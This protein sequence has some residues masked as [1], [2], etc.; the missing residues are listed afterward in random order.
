MPNYDFHQLSPLD[1]ERLARDLLQQEWSVRLESFKSGR[2]KGIDLRYASGPEKLVVQVK[3][4]LR[5]GIAGLIRDLKKEDVKVRKLKPSRYA[6]VTSVP[7]SQEDKNKI[8]AA[9][10]SAPLEV[11]DIYGQED[12]N[13]FLGRYPDIEKAHPKLWLTSQAILER[14]LNNAEVTRSEFE[15]QKIHQQIR[16]YAQTEA[17]REAEKRLA[18]ESVVMIA[19]PPGIGKTT[20]ANML[21]YEH[22]SQGWQ[23][24]V[25]DRDINEGAKLFKKDVNQIFYFDDFVGATL[26]GEGI[27][28]NDKALLSFI[29]MVRVNPSSRLILTT[30]EHLYEQAKTRSERLRH[31]NLDADRIVL[32]LHDYTIRQRAQ[33]LYNHIYFSDLPKEHVSALLDHGFYRNIIHHDK[34]NP[35]VIEWMATRQ[36]IINVPAEEYCN[37]VSQ[38][39]QDPIEIWRHAYEEELSKHAQTLLLILWSSEGRI[40]IQILERAFM[41][42]HANRV[43]KY[44][45]RSSPHNFNRALKELSGSFITPQGK[46]AVGVIDPSV[47]DLLSAV[48]SEAP[49]NASDI[50]LSTYSF[51]QIARL[52]NFARQDSS[53]R[54]LQAIKDSA[55]E[56]APLIH[57][58]MCAPRRVDYP[59]G[60]STWAESS[61]PERLSII[62]SLAQQTCTPEYERLVEPMVEAVLS[63]PLDE[64]SDINGLVDVIVKIKPRDSEQHFP[65]REKLRA[66][67]FEIVKNGCCSDELHQATRLLEETPA[68]AEIQSLKSGFEA[69]RA[70][71]FYDERTNCQTSDDFDV[72]ISDL[73]SI[74][75]I[76]DINTACMIRDVEDERQKF[77]E[78][79]EQ[80]ADA[81]YDQY[82]E[83]W[84]EERHENESIAD[85]FESLKSDN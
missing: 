4:Y 21:I 24:I 7:L 79:Q 81:T 73:N 23:A 26:I 84:R 74:G 78:Q 43:K 12:L 70:D 61:Y 31:A 64:G 41:K 76:L 48:L 60:T 67:V 1:L 46:V 42:F 9:V 32:R 28:A 50:L 6:V 27:T 11:S 57:Q 8:I 29:A 54:V 40:A 63:E 20:L 2:D 65:L 85:M 15:V 17:L 35:R 30:R 53:G 62:I 33:I 49:D 19:G 58:L 22:L 34:F 25:I 56:A 13:N 72:L 66:R 52:L 80:Y 82:K 77:E 55:S 5:T 44:G 39:L 38:L 37:F 51:S 71:Y 14:V 68:K 45:Y 16:R 69:Y 47:L 83:Q 59:N 36:R 75:K 3:H 18:D 10:P